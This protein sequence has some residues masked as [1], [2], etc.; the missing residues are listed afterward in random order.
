MFEEDQTENYTPLQRLRHSSAH[1]MADAVQSLFPE[2]KLAIGPAIE[3][4]FYYDIDVPRPLTQE[5]L[6]K[7][8]ARMQEIIDRNEPFV[9]QELSKAEAIE[10]FKK[11]G[12]IYKLEIIAAIPGDKVT[13]YKHG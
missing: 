8:E 2:A 10:L 13:L 9:C 3:T 7:I 12:E 4:G 11:R 6:E 5:D 1:V